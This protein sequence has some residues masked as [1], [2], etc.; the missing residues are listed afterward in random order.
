VGGCNPTDGR[1]CM[2][3]GGMNT[4]NNTT[5]E[6]MVVLSCLVLRPIEMSIHGTCVAGKNT[7]TKIIHV[8]CSTQLASV[9]NSKL[10]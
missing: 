9:Y 6:C 2:P 5:R 4:C 7:V 1:H 10:T 3:R 8:R